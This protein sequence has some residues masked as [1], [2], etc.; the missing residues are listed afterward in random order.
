MN[1]TLQ[2]LT[3]DH[4]AYFVHWTGLLAL[5]ETEGRRGNQISN[6]W[7]KSVEVRQ[8]MGQA[9]CDLVINGPVQY[10]D[11]SYL[12]VFGVRNRHVTAETQDRFCE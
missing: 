7:T 2:Q 11:E 4:I 5:E 8:Q 9:I 3:A 10:I 12:H 6:M 1:S